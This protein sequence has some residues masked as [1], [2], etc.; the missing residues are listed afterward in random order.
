MVNTM[1]EDKAKHDFT[2][3]WDHLANAQ[4][5]LDIITDDNWPRMVT[6]VNLRIDQVMHLLKPYIWDDEE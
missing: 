1:T 2:A 3:I 6:E 4:Q 5:S